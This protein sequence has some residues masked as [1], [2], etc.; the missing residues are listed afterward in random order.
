MLSLPVLLIAFLCA[1][2]SRRFILMMYNVLYSDHLFEQAYARIVLHMKEL[3]EL[4]RFVVYAD[5]IVE[6]CAHRALL[7]YM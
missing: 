5:F 3:V 7:I 6:L 1:L 2:M 4:V